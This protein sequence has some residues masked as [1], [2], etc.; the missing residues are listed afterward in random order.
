MD[1][2]VLIV[3]DQELIRDLL[4]DALK[5]EHYTVLSAASAEQALALLES[6][7]VDVVISDEV[8][9]GMAG[10]DFLAIVRRKYPETIRMILTGRARLDSAIKAINEGEVYR[11]FTK[12]CNIVDLMVSIK[13]GLNQKALERENRNLLRLLKEKSACEESL[14]E[15][16]PEIFQVKRDAGGAVIIDE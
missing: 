6:N 14:K 13:Q 10:S 9:P 12:P 16:H 1:A 15:Q 7:P 5:R 4:E 2:T 3:D 11:F 8:M